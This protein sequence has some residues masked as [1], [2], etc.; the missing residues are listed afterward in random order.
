MVRKK[1]VEKVEFYPSEEHNLARLQ[2]SKHPVKT[3]VIYVQRRVIE[4][5]VVTPN[6]T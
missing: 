6:R 1:K 2:S 5:T 3:Q 4:S